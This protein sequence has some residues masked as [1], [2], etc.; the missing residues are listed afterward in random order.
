M[1]WITNTKYITHKMHIM[2]CKSEKKGYTIQLQ[3]IPFHNYNFNYFRLI[4]HTIQIQNTLLLNYI[5]LT[6]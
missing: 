2:N 5:H 6:E 3:C 1:Y 4:H